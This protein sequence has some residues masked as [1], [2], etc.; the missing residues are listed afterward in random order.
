LRAAFRVIVIF[1]ALVEGRFSGQ[2]S[3]PARHYGA[4]GMRPLAGSD[5]AVIIVNRVTAVMPT[6]TAP[7]TAKIICQG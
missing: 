1:C 4:C 3:Q 2:L 7:T 6:A 5:G